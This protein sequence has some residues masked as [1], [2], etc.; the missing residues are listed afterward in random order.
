MALSVEPVV[1]VAAGGPPEAAP[2]PFAVVA[3]AG[4]EALVAPDL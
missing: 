1:P 3:D 4:A 2:G